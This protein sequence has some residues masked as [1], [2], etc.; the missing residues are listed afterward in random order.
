MTYGE[1][2]NGTSELRS[3]IASFVNEVFAPHSVVEDKHVSMC[4][5]AG[6]AVSN[7]CFCIGE[8]GDGILVGRPLYTGFFPDIKFHAKIKPVLVPMS[9]TDPLS[10]EAVQ[11]YESA[12]VEAENQGT[13]VR[14]ILLSNPHNP[15]GRPYTKQAL[16]GILRLCNKYSI[17]LLSDEVYARSWFPSADFPEPP[18]FVSILSFDLK[19][20]IDPALVH[21]LYGLSKDFCANGIRIGCLISPFNDQ[22]LQAFKSI[23]NFTRASQLAEHV[24]LKLLSD[25]P[26]LDWYFPEL[27]KRLT[28]AYNCTTD[29][30]K[31]H[32]VPYSA[33]SVSSFL[34]VDLHA[35]L[36]EDTEDAELASNWRMVKA[37]VWIAMG[38]TFGSEKH[39][40][41]G[42]TFATPRDELELGLK[43]LFKLLKQVKAEGAANGSL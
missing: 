21:V 29:Q 9:D 11:H 27:R 15:F 17:H 10:A 40:N 5:G 34:W 2:A 26:F 41:F 38:A 25:R 6:S 13:R 23:T 33:A 30:L 31:A 35:Y 43:R 8:P 39:G 37:G 12:L 19:Q 24:W 14:G 4:N 3:N 42:I 20:Y 7:F 22:M 32:D 18:P 16:E 36:D 28:D 1:G